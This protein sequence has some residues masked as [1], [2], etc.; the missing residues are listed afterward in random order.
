M[1]YKHLDPATYEIRMLVIKDARDDGILECSL[2]HTSLVDP[3]PYFALSYRWGNPTPAKQII[4][5]DSPFEVGANLEAALKQ[6]RSHGY[7]RVWADA[8]C[9][10]QSDLEERSLQVRNMQHIYSKAQKVVAWIG[11]DE[12]DFA[13]S[14]V[15]L[16]ETR[17]FK[18]LPARRHTACDIPSNKEIRKTE[19]RLGVQS[20]SADE[21]KQQR[22]RIFGDFFDLEYWKRVWIIQELASGSEIKIILGETEI[23]WNSILSAI[24]FLGKHAK[25]IPGSC[26]SY[27][28][29]ARLH[30]FRSRFLS[31]VPAPITLFEALK[32]S[33]YAVATDPRDKIY[34][35]LGLTSDG[36]KI[37]PFPNYQQ[38]LDQILES[39]TEAMFVLG[40]SLDFICMRGLICQKDSQP[41]WVPDWTNFWSRPRTFQEDRICENQTSYPAVPIFDIQKP[42]VLESK[43]NILG[44]VCSLSSSL[45]PI[46]AAGTLS[47][48]EIEPDQNH[49]FLAALLRNLRNNYPSGIA[50]ALSQSL[51]L[52]QLESSGNGKTGGLSFCT[53]EDCFHNLWKSKDQ[54]VSKNLL[55]LRWLDE[56]SSLKIGPL[57][58][59]DWAQSQSK[60]SRL[61]KSLNLWHLPYNSLDQKRYVEA[62]AEIL[63]SSM[64]LMVT[65]TGYIGLAPPATQIGDTVCFIKGCS[66]PVVLRKRETSV[67][68]GQSRE[69]RVIGGAYVQIDQ[70]FPGSARFDTWADNHFCNNNHRIVLT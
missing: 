46:G 58:L 23:S 64:R 69:Y 32:W 29:A 44:A 36:H 19:L 12:K 57:S 62:M 65:R 60:R 49:E 15:Y 28:N 26:Q 35:L 43:G 34:A 56:N 18:W 50:A 31:D 24:T 33:H 6:L 14:V 21:W 55:L 42:G 30:Q 2:E 7:R 39:M 52:D 61:K 37:V 40:R 20:S 45:S 4:V 53:P 63:Q 54:E 48:H 51:C 3:G 38:P 11:K 1:H 27:Q 10:N 70:S 67:M 68:G 22:W 8:L 9:I 59:Q 5:D 13:I 66:E 47:C 17:Y 25:E 41:S 16:L